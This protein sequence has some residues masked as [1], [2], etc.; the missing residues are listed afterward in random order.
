MQKLAIQDD[1]LY[2]KQYVNT[3]DAKLK[4][5]I[6]KVCVLSENVAIVYGLQLLWLNSSNSI[7]TLPHIYD[8]KLIHRLY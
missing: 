2:D 3:V 4:L 7:I 5:K 8:L 1:I 6:L